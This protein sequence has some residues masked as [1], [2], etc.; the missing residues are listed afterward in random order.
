MCTFVLDVPRL[1]ELEGRFPLPLDGWGGQFSLL[2]GFF[3]GG[4][5]NK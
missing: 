4:I 5:C 1:F 3:F 2:A